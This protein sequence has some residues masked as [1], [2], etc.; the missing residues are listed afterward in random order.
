MPHWTLCL[1]LSALLSLSACEKKKPMGAPPPQE[2]QVLTMQTQATAIHTSLPGRT[3]AFEIAQVRPQVNGVLQKRLFVEGSDVVAGQQLYQ[4]D[5]SIYQAQYD[6]DRAQLLRAQASQATAKAKL[7]RY[8]P[9]ARAHA[10]S[11]QEYDDALAAEREAEADIAQAKATMETAATNLA[12]THVNAPIS[13]RIGR[14]LS[15]VG[16]LV[17]ANQTTQI[18]TVTRL[19]PIYVDVNLAATDLLRFQRELANGRLQRAD[20]NAAAV[21][22]TLED[23]YP[24]DQPGKLQFSEVN[25]DTATSS[26]VVRA[27]FPNPDH[28]LLPGMFVHAEIDEGTDPNA[29][30][31]PQQAVGRDPH[32]QA[33]VM[34]VGDDNK[35]MIRNIKTVQTVDGD[36]I[37]NEGLKNGDRVVIVGRAKAAPG[38]TVRPV[39][40]QPSDSAPDAAQK[41][42]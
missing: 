30:R 36:W 26:V 12:Y 32:G 25:V 5:P 13:G 23:G 40:W 1:P 33:T 20:G 17:T 41:A 6:A 34:I 10:V 27:L 9:L 29:F 39:P 31:V 14:S 38:A 24:Y 16:A 18:A 4:V 22:L 19:D 2:V 3:E 37:V 28:T 8:E 15:T 11:G 35:A 21:K 7:S 42:G